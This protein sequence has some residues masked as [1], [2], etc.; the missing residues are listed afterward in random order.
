MTNAKT[1]DED[2]RP[3]GEVLD[4]LSDT[5]ADDENLAHPD[6]DAEEISE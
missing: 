4:G 2:S 1:K 3:C 6:Y 5:T